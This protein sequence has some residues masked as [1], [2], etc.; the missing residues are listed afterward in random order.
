VA[1]TK[2]LV[3]DDDE[4]L[5]YGRGLEQNGF[6]VTT[7]ATVTE[8]LEHIRYKQYDVLLS[9]SAIPD[10]GDNLSLETAMHNANH[11]AVT[12]VFSENPGTEVA[13]QV[14]QMQIDEIFERPMDLISL[15]K[16]IK[17]GVSDGPLHPRVVESVATILDRETQSAIQEW[18]ARA[19][20]EPEL[21]AV[22]MSSEVRCAYLTQLFRD[23]VVRLR[24]HKP[25]GDKVLASVGAAQH[26]VDR[27]DQGYT[28]AMM[29]TESRMLQVTIFHTLHKHLH[30]I[31]CS[32]L[33]LGVMAIADE[34][35]SQLA[36]A[37]TSYI[38]RGFPEPA[39]LLHRGPS[40][41]NVL[42][43]EQLP[44]SPNPPPDAAWSTEEQPNAKG[45]Q[46]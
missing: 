13:A 37:M 17:N 9:K 6:E 46:S 21:M 45:C 1:V 36:Q 22:Q 32:L 4:I 34:C 39:E 35:D 24:S 3:I 12:L 15:V 11:D 10:D 18:Y 25:L 43:G 44:V 26:G 5:T 7:A 8:A 14:V 27:R 2:I 33:L 20:L 16:R 28:A 30:S 31:D 40:S 42:G 23:L 38:E 19:Q 41:S 29:V